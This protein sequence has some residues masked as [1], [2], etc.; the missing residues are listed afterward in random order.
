[1]RHSTRPSS[2]SLRARTSR[3]EAGPRMLISRLPCHGP[4]SVAWV[5]SA[6]TACERDSELGSAAHV[7]LSG[8]SS[9]MLSLPAARGKPGDWP[10]LE[11]SCR[12]RCLKE[13]TPLQGNR[14][15][16]MTHYSRSD[17]KAN[18]GPNLRR[19]NCPAV[20]GLLLLLF[21]LAPLPFLTPPLFL[22]SLPLF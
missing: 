5:S 2:V 18:W 14:W 20:A 22:A 4:G 16:R 13:L 1:M 8:I 19:C 21:I 7:G 15:R 17:E 11:R 12:C 9:D 6:H 10:T 3:A